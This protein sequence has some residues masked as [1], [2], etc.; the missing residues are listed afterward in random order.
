MAG[1]GD[2]CLMEGG[3]DM[4]T[5]KRL[6]NRFRAEY[7]RGTKKQ[8]GEVLDRLVAVGMGRSTARRLLSQAVGSEERPGPGRGRRPKY[9]EEA[10]RLLERLWLLMGM[11][12]G[13]YMKAMLDQWIPALRA[14]GELDDVDGDA[15]EQV[16]SMSA[17]TIDR[18][19]RPLKRAAMPRGMSLTRPAGEHLRNS[20]RI[21]KCAD[22]IARLPGLAEADTVAHCGPRARGEFAR[23]LTMVDYATN[24]TVSVTVRNNAKSNIRRAVDLAIPLFPFPVTCFDSDNGTE[25]VNDELIDWLQ[26]KDIEQTR[27]RPYRKDDQATVESRNN[28][29][30]RRFAFY[31]R[32]DTEEQRDLPD[33][34][35]AKTYLLLNLFTPTRKPARIEQ[36][37]D[38]RRRTVYDRPRTPWAR[39]LEYDAA[40]RADGGRGY[41]DDATRTRIEN[42]IAS[43]NPAWLGRE[44]AAIQ[45]ELERL[46]RERTEGMARR[47][48]LD[49]GYLGK[50]IER[51]R[52]D[53]EQDNK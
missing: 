17:S 46:S 37:R 41:V 20:V 50:V 42:L 24:W 43:T 8:K 23:T 53:A 30:V 9:G 29:V 32:C 25:S 40:S 44:I 52:A 39:V 33:R 36:G 3:L 11:P 1:R 48:G 12:C 47:Q 51:M 49:M 6:A 13:P 16:C 31:W 27:S 19:L 28:H 15:L 34:L 21:R 38:G 5:R 10:Q 45:D 2:A 7:A 14:D 35:W 26:H 18:R 4:A 22:E